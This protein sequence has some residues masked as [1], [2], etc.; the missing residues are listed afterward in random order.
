MLENMFIHL[1]VALILFGTV[2]MCAF[3]THCRINRRV[4]QEERNTKL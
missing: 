2:F 3:I 1:K 4:K